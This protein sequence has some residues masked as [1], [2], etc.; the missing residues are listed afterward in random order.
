MAAVLCEGSVGRGSASGSQ[1]LWADSVERGLEEQG[2]APARQEGSPGVQ[3]AREITAAFPDTII[4]SSESL[5]PAS[6]PSPGKATHSSSEHHASPGEQSWWCSGL[7]AGADTDVSS[8]GPASAVGLAP[9]W[10][11]TC[12]HPG[13]W[14]GWA[15]AMWEMNRYSSSTFLHDLV[16]P[17]WPK[18]RTERSPGA[19]A[20]PWCSLS[21]PS[22]SS[23]RFWRH[24]SNVVLQPA[25]N[26]QRFCHESQYPMQ[27]PGLVAHGTVLC[28]FSPRWP[29]SFTCSSLLSC[30]GMQ[31]VR[32]RGMGEPRNSQTSPSSASPQAPQH[33]FSTGP[34]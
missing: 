14:P 2:C 15:L 4:C 16:T 30:L 31:G 12:S 26:T 7:R 17:D 23:T 1:W 24:Q 29:S 6:G 3:T 32:L 22:T 19:G 9:C 21:F 5:G 10:P 18:V 13:V 33:S 34:E 20:D 28:L 8:W 27:T 11:C 25:P